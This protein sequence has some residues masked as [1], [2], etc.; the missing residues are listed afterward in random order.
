MTNAGG[1]AASFVMMSCIGCVSGSPRWAGRLSPATTNVYFVTDGFGASA[2][3]PVGSGVIGGICPSAGRVTRSAR[4]TLR[5][6]SVY[7]YVRNKMSAAP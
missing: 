1:F 7:A 3:A 4:R 6:S 2:A 5:M